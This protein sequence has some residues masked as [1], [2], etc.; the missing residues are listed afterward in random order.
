[1]FCSRRVCK[2][3]LRKPQLNKLIMLFQ[4]IIIFYITFGT[5]YRKRPFSPMIIHNI[6]VNYYYYYYSRN[7]SFFTFTQH[8]VCFIFISD[9]VNIKMFRYVAVTAVHYNPANCIGHTVYPCFLY[10]F[11]NIYSSINWNSECCTRFYTNIR[12]RLL[13]WT[14]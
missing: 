3:N 2:F 10:R 7:D 8:V 9:K 14:R 11:K 5:S 12:Y 13:L 6:I 4:Q 1:M